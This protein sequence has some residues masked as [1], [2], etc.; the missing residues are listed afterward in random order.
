VGIIFDGKP[1][2]IVEDSAA[3]RRLTVARFQKG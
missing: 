2:K 1:L 3:A